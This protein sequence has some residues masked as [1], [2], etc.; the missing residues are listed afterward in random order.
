MPRY[1][2]EDTTALD[3]TADTAL[4]ITA[5]A[6]TAH[7]GRVYEFHLSFAAVGDNKMVS[8]VLRTTTTGTG[9][10]PT[11]EPW[12]PDDVA[13]RAVATGNLSAEPTTGD[14]LFTIDAYQRLE[15]I[16]KTPID[17]PWI[18]P[19]T[20]NSG[21]AGQSAHASI[22]TDYRVGFVWEE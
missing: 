3:S 18:W 15:L 1:Y 22:T 12:D 9:D 8:T 21:I 2:C 16:Y 7:R 11:I 6:S 14:R 13:A 19:A 17:R 5:N 10:S 20:T 4:N